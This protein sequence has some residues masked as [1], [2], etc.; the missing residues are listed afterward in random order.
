MVVD[1]QHLRRFNSCHFLLYLH[2]VLMQLLHY[3][4]LFN[5]LHQVQIAEDALSTNNCLHYYQFQ[6]S[7]PKF[8]QV[9]IQ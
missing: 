7:I 8:L 1:N 5:R 2:R 6:E 9:N 4:Q 3:H